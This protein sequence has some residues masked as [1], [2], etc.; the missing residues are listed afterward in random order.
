MSLMSTRLSRFLPLLQNLTP[1][2]TSQVSKIHTSNVLNT[3]VPRGPRKFLKYNEKVYPPQAIG[4]EPRPAFV[5]HQRTNIKYSP[6]KMWYIA[7]MIRGMSVDEAIKQLKFVNKKGA[8]DV[9][10]VLEEAEDLAAKKHNVEFPSN[11]WVAESFV[12]KGLVYKG[13]RRHARKR[14]GTVEYFHCHYYVRLE[15]GT[16]P[17]KYYLNAP[18]EPSEMLEDWLKQM[19]NRE[20]L[21]SL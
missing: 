14:M 18:Q 16:P 1:L 12:T 19:R 3:E 8:K 17:E 4:E 15:E 2:V 21:S 13:V 5:C 20:I 9:R 6:W 11:M 10:E 7:C